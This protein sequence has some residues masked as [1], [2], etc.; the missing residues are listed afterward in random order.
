[1]AKEVHYLDEESNKF[2]GLTDRIGNQKVVIM[3]RK[4]H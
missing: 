3:F 2:Y 4:E 1:M